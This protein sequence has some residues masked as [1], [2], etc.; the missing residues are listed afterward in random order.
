MVV[1][2]G[3]GAQVPAA[4]P[5][6]GVKVNPVGQAETVDVALPAFVIVAMV[7]VGVDPPE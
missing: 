3:F 4:P 1:V 5:V 7:Q 2:P 6:P